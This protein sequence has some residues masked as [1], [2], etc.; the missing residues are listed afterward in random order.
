VTRAPGGQPPR[1][2][3]DERAGERVNVAPGHGDSPLPHRGAG[4]P[5]DVAEDT[6][7][8]AAEVRERFGDR[9]ADLVG[10]VTIPPRR[11]DETKAEVRAVYLDHLRGAPHDA[12]T[13]KFAD[14]VSNVQ[15]L[16]TH[17][18]HEKARSYYRETVTRILPL[19]QHHPWFPDWFEAWRSEFRWL[20][21]ET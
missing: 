10:W 5:H 21:D 12:L 11:E 4:G 15:R 1:R 6:P 20:A 16:D 18:R 17:R 19:A 8:T 7:C 9:T 13:V 2:L 3:G 14:R